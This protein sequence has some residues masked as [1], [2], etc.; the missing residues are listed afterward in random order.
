MSQKQTWQII[1]IIGF[2]FMFII[3]IFYIFS[4]NFEESSGGSFHPKY[5]DVLIVNGIAICVYLYL[6]LFNPMNFRIYAALHFFYGTMELLTNGNI[7]AFIMY[8]L[9]CLF[10]YRDGFFQKQAKRKIMIVVL[11]FMG[12][13]CIQIYR[14]GLR[15]FFVNFLMVFAVLIIFLLGIYLFWPEIQG[16]RGN[17][18][19]AVLCLSAD[20]FS[21]RDVLILRQILRGEK[22]ESIAAEHGIAVSTL[23]NNLAL[24]Y[25]KLNLT[26]RTAFLLAYANHEIRFN[27]AEDV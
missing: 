26:D 22:Y 7:P 27:S 10:L 6:V 16:L 11:V 14:F 12:C 15:Q 3:L 1:S 19:K 5:Y 23:K 13:F 17:R 8:L 9:S 24:L 25:K 4:M 18:K 20:Q 2:F 21:E